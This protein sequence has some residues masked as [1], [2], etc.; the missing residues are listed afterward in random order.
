MVELK[1]YSYTIWKCPH[2]TIVIKTSGGTNPNP[3]CKKCQK[4]DL[5]I[6]MKETQLGRMDYFGAIP[7]G[8]VYVW[9]E[10]LCRS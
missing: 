7:E 5:E 9:K 4:L 8:C 1:D 6:L 2:K 3:I 10:H